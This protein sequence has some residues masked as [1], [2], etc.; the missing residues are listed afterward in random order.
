MISIK[1]IAALPLPPKA[2]PKAKPGHKILNYNASAMR[3]A[4]L[5][6]R[7]DGFSVRKAA[8]QHGVPKTTLN[9]KLRGIAPEESTMGP[10]PILTPQEEDKLAQ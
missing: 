8:N 9:N 10:Q 2:G 1:F 3:A 7:K 6:V 4:M 5:G